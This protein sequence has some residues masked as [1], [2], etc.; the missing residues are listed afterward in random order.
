M[1]FT[2]FTPVWPRICLMT[3]G[4]KERLRGGFMLL[5]I[6][7]SF[8]WANLSF[9]IKTVLFILINTLKLLLPFDNFMF[10]NTVS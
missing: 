6:S 4:V 1:K 10:C 5:K 7:G 2:L 9:L 3:P 8:V